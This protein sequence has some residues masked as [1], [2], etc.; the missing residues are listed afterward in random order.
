[1]TDWKVDRNVCLFGAKMPIHSD[2]GPFWKLSTTRLQHF[3]HTFHDNSR[4]DN[5]KHHKG[6]L[7]CMTTNFITFAQKMV[8]LLMNVFLCVKEEDSVKG[9]DMLTAYIDAKQLIPSA[10]RIQQTGFTQ[11]SIAGKSGKDKYVSK[12]E[13]DA[14]H[15]SYFM[16]RYT[17]SCNISIY[18]KATALR[19]NDVGL[20]TV[21][22]DT[23]LCGEFNNLFL[24][25]DEC[26]EQC[27][28]L[29]FVTKQQFLKNF[30]MKHTAIWQTY[31]SNNYPKYGDIK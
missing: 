13:D 2:G 15:T 11:F 23:I 18:N 3:L 19:H 6:K 4:Q 25:Q 8:D 24:E 7:Y 5:K 28:R 27:Y 31:A 20:L 21:E 1:M 12:T 22:D 30:R 26:A 14:L 29:V 17:Y 10:V 9:N 16:A